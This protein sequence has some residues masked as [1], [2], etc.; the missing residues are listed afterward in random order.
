MLNEVPENRQ[1]QRT[2]RAAQEAFF[3]LLLERRYDEMKIGDV[4][5]RAGIGRSTFYEHYTGKDDLLRE[6]LSGP[7]SVLADS[8]TERHDPAKL[9][10]VIEHF[11]EHRR[12]GNALFGSSTREVAVKT[13]AALFESRLNEV[14]PVDGF[15]L[16]PILIAAQLAAGQF[17][18][19]SAWCAGHA[20]ASAEAISH[21]LY[22]T[23]KASLC[24]PEPRTVPI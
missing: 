23:A 8:I 9:Q 18:L 2:R 6:G 16:P 22:F 11:W 14:S 3:A 12:I 24:G 19:I 20:S 10:A 1:V 5:A 15:G 7:F 21:R 13:L 4:I 17:A